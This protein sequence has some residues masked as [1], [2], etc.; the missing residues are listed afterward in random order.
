MLGVIMLKLLPLL[1][2]LIIDRVEIKVMDS[3][4]RKSDWEL[5]VRNEEDSIV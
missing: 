5:R 1:L 4:G 3:E 2:L